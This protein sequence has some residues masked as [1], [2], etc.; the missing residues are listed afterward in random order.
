VYKH[1]GG[2]GD[3]FEHLMGSGNYTY[4][5]GAGDPYSY[6]CNGYGKHFGNNYGCGYGDGF[7]INEAIL[8]EDSGVLIRTVHD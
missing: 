5:T 3:G 4:H 7:G 1:P 6:I 8:L 2:D